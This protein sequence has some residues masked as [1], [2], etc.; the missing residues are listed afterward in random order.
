MWTS[1][2]KLTRVSPSLHDVGTQD[3]A[4]ASLFMSISRSN[5]DRRDDDD[6]F[7]GYHSAV[8]SHVSCVSVRA[9]SLSRHVLFASFVCWDSYQLWD[10]YSINKAV[11]IIVREIHEERK[12]P[13][14]H[15]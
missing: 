7:V 3:T 2:Y 5:R 11:E 1:R 12:F 9:R 8:I 6:A 15:I 14:N 4:L 10:C 13:H